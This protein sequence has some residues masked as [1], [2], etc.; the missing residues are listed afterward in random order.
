[1][2]TKD[3]NQKRGPTVGNATTEKR[4]AFLADKKS[5]EA[6]AR[7]IADSIG[8][9]ANQPDYMKIGRNKNQGAA[10]GL[11]NK[12]RGPTKGNK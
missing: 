6:T 5:K 8:A 1:M 10:V 12:G 4:T 9:R 11:V 3:I 2:A 7:E